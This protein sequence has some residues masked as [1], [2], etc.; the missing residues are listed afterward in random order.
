MKTKTPALLAGAAKVD[1]TPPLGTQLAG[2]IGRRR[3]AEMLVDPLFARALVLQSGSQKIC[4][5]SL[6]VLAITRKWSDKIRDGATERF[7]LPR[8][9][10]MVHTVQ[11]HAAP[12]IGHFFFNYE[13][14][15]IPPDM[16]W[17]KGGDDDYHPFAVERSLEAIEK[18]IENMQ[19]VRIGLATGLESRVAFNRRFVLRDG[20]AVCHP[21]GAD[22]SN[23]LHIEGPIDPE[24]GVMSLISESLAPVAVL[25]HYTCHPVHGYPQRYV[26]GGWPGAWARGVENFYN[27]NCVAMVAN[28]CCGNVHHNDHLNPAHRN[29]VDEMATDLLETTRPLLK[30]LSLQESGELG[31][32]SRNLEIPLR[33]VPPEQLEEARELLEK[34][35]EP[36]WKDG[37]ENIAA[38]WDW[39]YAVMRLDIDRLRR[40]S[41]VFDYEIQAFRIGDIALLAVMGEPFVQGQLQIKMQSPAERTFVAHMSHGYVG[42]IPTPEALERGGYETW[43]SNG[44]KLVPEA[45]D[46]IVE[47]SVE[48]LDSIMCD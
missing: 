22:M 11:N 39:V 17:L 33:K 20:S 13:S 42:Y 14:D 10:A 36:I 43:T 31:F 41:P 7:G 46:M 44:S 23:I 16:D 15:Y 12:S 27:D 5:L 25:L 6:D 24:V 28:G 38:D 3:P 47:G 1:I 37:L 48:L 35:P 2:D 34:H 45:L 18:A 32:A 21:G 8:E 9:A 40:E 19:P 4:F 29:T 26:T 30:N